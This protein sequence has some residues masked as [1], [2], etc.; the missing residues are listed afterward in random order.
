MQDWNY[1]FGQCFEVTVEM[2]CVKFPKA[3]HLYDLWNEHKYSL[4][5]FI[6]LAHN[7]IN[8][9]FK[10]D[11]FLFKQIHFHF[12]ASFLTSRPAVAFGTLQ[13]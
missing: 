1:V 7:T 9:K 10:K 5:H 4:L 8:G 3:N 12:Q 6:D 2:N 11:H 13:S